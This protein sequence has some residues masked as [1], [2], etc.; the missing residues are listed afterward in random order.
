M[1]KNE[2]YEQS[3][4]I[5][6]TIAELKRNMKRDFNEERVVNNLI[7]LNNFLPEVEVDYEKNRIDGA[8]YL[9]YEILK[10]DEHL[11]QVEDCLNKKLSHLA[12][13]LDHETPLRDTDA[14]DFVSAKKIVSQFASIE[15][16]EKA[17][18]ENY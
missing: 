13:S 4:K 18:N 7:S 17:L 9:A 12:I 1:N 11:A 14:L 2:Q 3:V 6:D 15:K 5:V 16:K 10:Q 8:T